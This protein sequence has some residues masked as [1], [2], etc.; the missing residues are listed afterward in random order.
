MPSEEGSLRERP[1]VLRREE[2]AAGIMSD[3][4]QGTR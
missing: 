1:C 3:G 2:D 4:S